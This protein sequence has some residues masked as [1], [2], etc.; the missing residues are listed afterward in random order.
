MSIQINLS[1]P[2]SV[3]DFLMKQNQGLLHDFSKS[4]GCLVA[5]SPGKLKDRQRF[6]GWTV[7]ELPPCLP[8]SACIVRKRGNFEPECWVR[9]DYRGYRKAFAAYLEICHPE[10][11]SILSMN[12]HV[13]HLEPRFRFSAGDVYFVRLHL[14]MKNINMAY[15]A[16]FE[17]NFYRTERATPIHG[18]IHMSWLGFCKASGILPPGKN[19][20]TVA[21]DAWAR[22][23]A[24]EFAQQSGESEQLA[25]SGLLDVLRLGY[26]GYY[27]GAASPHR[28]EPVRL[29]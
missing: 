24:R 23:H 20:G 17:K 11:N 27:S 25:Y 18:A 6:S 3:D 10:F 15:G 7:E 8:S 5:V 2:L 26:T 21:W 29:G 19:A 16:G 13:D 4:D 1:L 12:V 14:V 28:P 22:K 9:W